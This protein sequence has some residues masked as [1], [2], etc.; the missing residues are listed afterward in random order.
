[1]PPIAI[2]FDFDG[3]LADSEPL[4][5]RALQVIVAELGITIER[6]EYYERYLG[7]D[8]VGAMKLLAAAH[9]QEWT[10]QQISALIERKSVVFEEM[11]QAGAVLYP[12]APACVRRLATKYPLGIASGALKHEIMAILHG[13]GLAQH[14]RFVVASGDTPRSKPAPDPYRRAAELHKLPP[15]SCLAIEDSRWGIASAK[16][17]GLRCVGI[18]TT[19]GAHELPGADAVIESLDQFTPALVE[20]LMGT[21]GEDPR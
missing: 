7:Y 8:D 12:A 19:Y 13:S 9:G 20:G 3:V 1:M 2:V 15:A 16:A 21:A 10:D 17:A 6:D 14:F 18:T 4:H 5:L 11:L